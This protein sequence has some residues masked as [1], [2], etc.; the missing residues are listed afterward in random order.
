MIYERELTEKILSSAIEVH[1]M[2]GPGL[3]ESIYE[4]CLCY[5]LKKS[6]IE[7]QRQREMPV[8]YKGMEFSCGY[9]IDIF[10]SQKV[11]LELKCVEN[12]LP[13]H[14]AQLLTYMKLS[15]AKIGFI[16]NF[17][18]PILKNGIKRMVL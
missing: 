13:I 9:R 7:F 4:E 1:R 14:M 15:G 5:E 3:L 17:Y 10:I 2:L 16:L 8:H 18:V 12:I 11:I 6:G